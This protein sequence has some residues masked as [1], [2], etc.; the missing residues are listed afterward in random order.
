MAL[1]RW[2][3]FTEMSRLRDEME[4]M[5]DR[6]FEL[7]ERRTEFGATMWVPSVDVYDKDGNVVVEAELPGM[8]REEVEVTL[9]DSTLTISGEM[10]REAE[11]KEEGYYRSERRY[12]RFMRSI[13]LPTPVKANEVKAKFE[14]GVLKVTLPKAE[15]AAHGKRVPVE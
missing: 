5:M 11:K 6:F 13:P 9:E 3:P 7:P 8:K 14:D 4:R 2:S 1:T 12:G 15:E 10:K